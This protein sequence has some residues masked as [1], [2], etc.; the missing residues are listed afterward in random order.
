MRTPIQYPENIKILKPLYETDYNQ[1]GF[2][3]ICSN[4]VIGSLSEI[5][6]TVTGER[7]EVTEA[8]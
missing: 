4:W 2:G 7:K 6:M 5:T 8:G 1:L 3:N